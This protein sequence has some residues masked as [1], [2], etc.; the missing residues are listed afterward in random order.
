MLM[1]VEAEA[2]SDVGR[3]RQQNQDA[4]LIDDELKLFVVADGMGGHAGGQVASRLATKTIRACVRASAR[5]VPDTFNAYPIESS[6]AREV[7]RSAVETAGRT[8]YSLA[9]ERPDLHG[10][11]TTTTAVLA[12]HGIAFIAHV[13]DSRC[14]LVRAGKAIQVSCDHSL[15]EEQVKAGTI[16]RA[17]AQVSRVK[18][19]ILRSVGFD[20]D[21]AVD[22]SAFVLEPGDRI[23]LCSDGLSNHLELEEI[24]QRLSGPNPATAADLVAVA[25][26]RGGDDNITAVVVRTIAAAAES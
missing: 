22:V 25:N 14:Y 17:Q 20:E 11:G 3:M 7:L 16:T 21:T 23:L 12:V 1:R 8:I 5:A 18:N 26:E 4:F 24:A 9:Q 15:V 19:V 10:M 6:P 2:L 13:G